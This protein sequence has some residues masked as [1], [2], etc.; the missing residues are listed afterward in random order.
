[1]FEHR[2]RFGSGEVDRLGHQQP[3]RFERAGEHFVAELFVEDPLV[4]RVLI[5]HFEADVGFDDEVAVVNLQRGATRSRVDA[6]D[7]V[8]L[9]ECRMHLP[10]VEW[11]KRRHVEPVEPQRFAES[12]RIVG[13]GRKRRAAAGRVAPSPNGRA[14]SPRRWFP[15]THHRRPI[16]VERPTRWRFAAGREIGGEK[17]RA[18][19]AE[20]VAV[21]TTAILETDF[22][23]GRMHVHVDQLRRH[24]EP[25]EADRLPAREQ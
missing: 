24:V 21:K 18:Q 2:C 14:G 10:G 15:L 17:F 20:Q 8:A 22:L 25:Q 16:M 5:D 3:L 6:M 9:C 11:L 23:L 13:R 7:T 12:V 4:E 19:R 1:M